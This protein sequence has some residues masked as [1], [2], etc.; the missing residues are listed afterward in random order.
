V[1]RPTWHATLVFLISLS[2]V[3]HAEEWR[4]TFSLSGRPEISVDANDANLRVYAADR[5]DV[6]AVVITEGWKIGPGEVHVNDRQNG[7]KVELTVRTP[8]SVHFGFSFRSRTIRVELNVPRDS[9]LSLHS[10]DGNIRAENVNGKLHLD[11][12]DGEIEARGVEGT[13]DANTSDGNIRADGTFN[14]LDL[15]TGD[16]NIEAEAGSS[17]KMLQGWTLKTGDG[18]IVLRVPANFSAELDAH[19]GDGRV[20]VDFP[21]TIN[22]SMQESSIRGRLNGGGQALELR[23]GDGNI[24]LRKN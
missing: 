17:S 24:S 8:H 10:G 7:N 21:V 15:H 6:E 3:A 20:T 12:G 14:A 2:A 16:G 1:S 11:T 5:K 23:T 9:D 19:S 22:G 4:K 18:N 13:L